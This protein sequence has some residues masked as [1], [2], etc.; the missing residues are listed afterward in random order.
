MGETVWTRSNFGLEF[1]IGTHVA[2]VDPANP[3][4]VYLARLAQ[5]HPHDS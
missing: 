1:A 3:A 4:T 5:V 2:A